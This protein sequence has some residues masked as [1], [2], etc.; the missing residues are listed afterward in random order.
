M[1]FDPLA[2]CDH[3]AWRR[4]SRRSSAVH[5]KRGRIRRS[6]MRVLSQAAYVMTGFKFSLDLR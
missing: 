3:I 2:A 1:I 4:I 6:D 5:N